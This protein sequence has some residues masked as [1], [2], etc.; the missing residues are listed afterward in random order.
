MESATPDYTMGFGM[1]MLEAL[2]RYTAEA[3]AK[4]L[5]PYLRPGLRVLDFGCD[6]GAISVGLVKAVDPGEMHGVDMEA[7][8]IKVARRRDRTL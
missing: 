6:P 2:R 7:S 3:N 1:E 8:Q 4:H 5:L